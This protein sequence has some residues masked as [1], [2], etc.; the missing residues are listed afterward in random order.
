MAVYSADYHFEV[1][2]AKRLREGNEVVIFATG[3]TVAKALAVAEDLGQD[4]VE[5]GVVN[6]STIKPPG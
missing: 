5:A 1:G 3:H 4:G 2:K 6:V